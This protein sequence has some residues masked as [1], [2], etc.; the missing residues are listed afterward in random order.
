MPGQIQGQIEAQVRRALA[1]HGAG[2]LAEAAALYDEILAAA[3]D[4]GDILH[5][6]GICAFQEGQCGRAEGAIRKAIALS[7]A[8]PDYH[9][10]LSL[11][12]AESGAFA[13]AVA[14]AEQAH[15]LAPVHDGYRLTLA[16]A[17]YGA[18]RRDAAA[19]SYRAVL[20]QRPDDPKILSALAGIAFDWGDDGTAESL[21]ARAVGADPSY[22]WTRCCVSGDTLARWTDTA[23]ARVLFGQ[24]PALSGE[25]PGADPSRPLAFVSCDAAYLERYAVALARSV[26]RHAPGHDVHLHVMAPLAG[27]EARLDALRR[28]LS[29]ARLTVTRETPPGGAGPVYFSNMRFARLWQTGIVGVRPVLALDADSLVRGPLAPGAGTPVAAP[30]RPGIPHLNRRMLATSVLFR[31]DPQAAALLGAVATYILSALADGVSA[32]YLDQCAFAVAARRLERMTGT[33]VLGDLDR[34]FA[35]ERMSDRAAVWSAKGAHKKNTRYMTEAARL[36]A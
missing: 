4:R 13:N 14:A 5:L 35:D 31:P 27:V 3:P 2:R 36:A 25:M 34:R 6:R 17:L 7:P 1:L 16:D 30:L 12:L 26:D 24:F 8:E 19:E 22:A 29:S 15:R 21:F 20:D 11:V 28:S 23:R 10:S 9:N 18:G 32:W 33:P